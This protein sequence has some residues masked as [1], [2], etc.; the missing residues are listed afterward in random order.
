[1]YSRDD[2]T[3]AEFCALFKAKLSDKANA[4]LEAV[5][6]DKRRGCSGMIHEM[7][8]ITKAEARNK[9]VVAIGELQ[10]QR[11][12]ETLIV[13]ELCVEIEPLTLRAYSELEGGTLAMMMVHTKKNRGECM[14][15]LVRLKGFQL[16]EVQQPVHRC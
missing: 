10:R 2:W 8:R 9:Q 6:E 7:R 14:W 15:R 3:D 5:P 13:P 12:L 4:Q 11:K 1:M 16:E